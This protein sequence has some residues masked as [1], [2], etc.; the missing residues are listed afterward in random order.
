MP[1]FTGA[2]LKPA[3][4]YPW[5]PLNQGWPSTP[6]WACEK[7]HMENQKTVKEHGEF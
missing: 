2:K 1:K 3:M 4:V 6:H 7:S 5:P